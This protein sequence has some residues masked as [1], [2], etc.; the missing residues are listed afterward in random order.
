MTQPQEPQQPSRVEQMNDAARANGWIAP[1]QQQSR[2]PATQPKPRGRI[3]FSSF[4]IIL[5]AI[6][7]YAVATTFGWYDA[8]PTWL[9]P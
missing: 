9:Q 5:G 3:K 7:V 4:V 8:L 6:M 1:P 2:P